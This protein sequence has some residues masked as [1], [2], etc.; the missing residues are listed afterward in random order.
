MYQD[1][2]RS[3]SGIEV[4]PLLSLLLFV[5]LFVIVVVMTVRMDRERVARLA[6]LPLEDERDAG[7]DD[8]PAADGQH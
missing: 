1:I 5:T 8:R 2:L 4:Y 3:I 7:R 6:G